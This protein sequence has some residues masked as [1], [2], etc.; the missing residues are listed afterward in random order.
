MR[1]LAGVLACFILGSGVAVGQSAACIQD[2]YGN[3]YNFTIDSA[4]LYVYGSVTRPGGGCSLVWPLTGSYVTTAEGVG[5]E[6]T[7]SNPSFNDP[8]DQCVSQ[9][10]LKGKLPNFQWYY[11]DGISTLDQPGTW[12]AC[13]PT[14]SKEATGR[15]GRK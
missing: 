6:L 7:A 5:L 4:H 8:G 2:Q 13:G 11:P 9:Y 12:A 1:T 10:K 14:I 15:N 3:Q